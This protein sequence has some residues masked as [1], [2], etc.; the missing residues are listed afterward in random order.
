MDKNLY[1][2]IAVSTFAWLAGALTPMAIGALAVLADCRGLHGDALAPTV[3]Q[4]VAA[5]GVVGLL[6]A[7]GAG[8]IV[9][10]NWSGEVKS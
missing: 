2:R 3:G 8:L 9:F 10:F 6:L 7:W 1:N 4:G 5:G